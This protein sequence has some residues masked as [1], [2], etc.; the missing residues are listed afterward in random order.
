MDKK[1]WE[2]FENIIKTRFSPEQILRLNRISL[3]KYLIAKNEAEM[4][5]IWE[6]RL[7]LLNS[8]KYSIQTSQSFQNY[9]VLLLLKNYTKH[10]G[11]LCLYYFTP[12]WYIL[13]FIRTI[14]AKNLRILTTIKWE[15]YVYNHRLTMNRKLRSIEVDQGLILSLFPFTFSAIQYIVV[16]FKPHLHPNVLEH[17]LPIF[18]YPIQTIKWETLMLSDDAQEILVKEQNKMGVFDE[19]LLIHRKNKLKLFGNTRWLDYILVP[20][21]EANKSI[22]EA[23]LDLDNLP[24]KL[25]SAKEV[26]YEYPNIKNYIQFLDSEVPLSYKQSAINKREL[27]QTRVNFNYLVRAYYRNFLYGVNEDLISLFNK[28]QKKAQKVKTRRGP[29]KKYSTG[30]KKV[31]SVREFASIADLEKFENR[32]KF[33][34]DVEVA[35]LDKTKSIKSLETDLQVD[36]LN[37]ELDF[38]DDYLNDEYEDLFEENFSLQSNEYYQNHFFKEDNSEDNSSNEGLSTVKKSVEKNTQDKVNENTK[39]VKNKNTKKDFYT[40]YAELGE[41]LSEISIEETNIDIENSSTTNTNIDETSL[42]DQNILLPELRGAGNKQKGGKIKGLSE[43]EAAEVIS[44]LNT[45]YREDKNLFRNCEF[46]DQGFSIPITPRKMS[47][48]VYPDTPTNELILLRLREFLLKNETKTTLRVDLPPNFVFIKTYPVKYPDAPNPKN[49][50]VATAAMDLTPEQLKAYKERQKERQKEQQKGGDQDDLSLINQLDTKFYVDLDP[51]DPEPEVQ[52]TDPRAEKVLEDDYRGPAILVNENNDIRVISKIDDTKP[53]ISKTDGSAP[54]LNVSLN[55]YLGVLN[56]NKILKFID[57]KSSQS[58]S[59]ISQPETS[60]SVSTDLAVTDLE[61]K[62]TDTKSLDNITLHN[63]VN[64]TQSNVE[65]MIDDKEKSNK[66]KDFSKDEIPS[67]EET[68]DSILVEPNVVKSW[69][70][71]YHSPDN[72]IVPKNLMYSPYNLM[73][74]HGLQAF[75]KALNDDLTNVP[76]HRAEFE[77]LNKEYTYAI[78]KK[79][80]NKRWFVFPFLPDYYDPEGKQT[81]ELPFSTKSN[82]FV[83]AL[84]PESWEDRYASSDVVAPAIA[85]DAIKD[86]EQFENYEYEKKRSVRELTGYAITN[87][88]T[89]KVYYPTG[90]NKPKL[91]FGLVNELDYNFSPFAVSL[92]NKIALAT[93][94]PHIEQTLCEEEFGRILSPGIYKTVSKNGDAWEIDISVWEPLTTNSWL[95]VSQIGFSYIFFI[96]LKETMMNYGREFLAYLLEIFN[97]T[98]F[99]PPMMFDELKIL[100]GE[101]ETGFRVA[102]DFTKGF[103]DVVDIASLADELL[104]TLLYL[105]GMIT[106]PALAQRAQSLLLVGP[107]GTGKTL[108]VHALAHEAK[109]PVLTLTAK[110]SKEPAA[111]ERL[112]TEAH[113]LSPCIVFLDEVDSIASVRSGMDPSEHLMKVIRQGLD[114]SSN[115]ARRSRTDNAV[116]EMST[117]MGD[118]HPRILQNKEMFHM[119]VNRDVQNHIIKKN[120]DEYYR[121]GLLLKLLTELDG[122]ESRDGIVIIGATN[123]LDVLDPALL[124]PGRFI[125]KV[126][127]GLPNKNK[128]LQLFKHYSYMLGSDANIPWD[129]LVKVTYGFSAADIS[130]IMNESGLKAIAQASHHTLETIEHGIDRLTT[131]SVARGVAKDTKNPKAR[132]EFLFSTARS[133]YYQ[134]A[135]ALV[136]TLL[137][138]HPPVIVVHLWY[139]HYSVR[140]NQIQRTVQLEWLKYVCRGE[141]EHR[142]IGTYA[143]KAGEYLFLQD[144][145]DFIDISDNS[146]IGAQD[147]SIGQ[148]LVKLLV[149]NWYMY[150]E[151]MLLREPLPLKR[152]FNSMEHNDVREQYLYEFAQTYEKTPTAAKLLHGKAPQTRFPEKWWHLKLYQKYLN[153]EIQKWSSIYVPN[154]EEWKFNPYWVGPDRTFHQNTI[155]ANIG[156]FE[157][158][159][160]MAMLT[161]DYKMHSII[162]ESFN[163]AF[164]IVTEYRELLDQLA[165]EL[166]HN[167]ILREHTI[168][169]IF[170]NFGFDCENLKEDLRKAPK[171]N[172]LPEDFK[173]LYPSWGL[174]SDKPTI[175][176]V[177]IAAILNPDSVAEE[178][179][180]EANVTTDD[181]ENTKKNKGN[182]ENS[183]INE[184]T[185]SNSDELGEEDEEDEEMQQEKVIDILGTFYSDI[186]KPN[187]FNSNTN[188]ED[189]DLDSNLTTEN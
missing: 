96:V 77:V 6:F 46:E 143:G 189:Q 56:N 84:S 168:Y 29:S 145:G 93:E 58:S 107:P 158:L 42:N 137:K 106:N 81:K 24:K 73:K 132:K 163:L 18:S 138:Y 161:R 109:V 76:I 113:K 89:T 135:K 48:Y 188:K 23:F 100:L 85:K 35:N 62:I 115:L 125:R 101:K 38:E 90:N 61:N 68:K 8:S 128:R 146:N 176:W 177:D 127:L 36:E 164:L 7:S 112:F 141:L 172:P 104:D 136:G 34:E 157:K 174:N 97:T 186:I 63:P 80:Y 156:K 15:L 55:Y 102:K 187:P 87:I 167:E 2:R 129:Y 184:I 39:S 43:K 31:S 116:P 154:P 22:Q 124:R 67:G 1:Q 33:T 83:V 13:G 103:K 169:E 142:I 51:E 149:E 20:E 47:G 65:S 60:N 53:F 10:V 114:S 30:I 74:W 118:L 151:T 4:K 105:R 148:S 79:P 171:M 59:N 130:T 150:T 78:R 159:K 120:D 139:R 64:D 72:P 19:Y 170:S 92:F 166:L 71:N 126:R 45:F 117:I 173:I 98:G 27:Y 25:A 28:L 21:V 5:R 75:D 183:E 133:A 50:L 185:Y 54:I 95:V 111:F 32:F 9:K 140:Y 16:R 44:T 181:L 3:K 182:T 123:R 165:Y 162:M 70:T 14:K 49:L 122:I 52:P 26:T 153:G 108:L 82:L 99:L 91:N 175:R 144:Q 69:V 121:V 57:T 160:H 131:T 86:I 11:V 110:G 94:N 119:V 155:A 180:D 179:N 147:W 40:L 178:N 66:Q 12:G 88:P 152:N 17:T 41:L 134:A 37:E